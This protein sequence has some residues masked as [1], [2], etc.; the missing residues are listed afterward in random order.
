VQA[1]ARLHQNRDGG[2]VWGIRSGVPIVPGAL[3]TLRPRLGA[4]GERSQGSRPFIG[5]LDNRELMMTDRA[6]RRTQG[7]VI[8]KLQMKP[9]QHQILGDS[10]FT[11]RYVARSL[12]SPSS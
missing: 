3:I 8:S 1:R 7:R 2:A 4:G 9:V 5:A 12:N 11:R 6:P 10:A